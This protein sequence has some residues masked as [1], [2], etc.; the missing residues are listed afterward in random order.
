MTGWRIIMS[1]R[2][3]L[4]RAAALAAFISTPFLTAHPQTTDR[5]PQRVI[6]KWKSAA[7][8]TARTL[9]VQQA[10]STA[11]AR[12]GVSTAQLRTTATGANVMRLDRRLTRIEL[13]D[14]MQ[15]LAAD[16]QVEYVEE[17]RIMKRLL[18]PTDARYAEQWHYY[19][20][21]GGMNLPA[22]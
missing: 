21:N 11:E 8:A 20:N 13:T 2:K 18:T 5:P 14:F 9:D 10:M 17:D 12:L 7:G 19:E 15:T 16:P 1:K 6:V 3:R 22:R 4:V